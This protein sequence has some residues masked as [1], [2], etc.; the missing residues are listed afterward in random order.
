MAAVGGRARWSHGWQHHDVS[1]TVPSP[2]GL[3]RARLRWHEALAAL[4]ASAERA[5]ADAV[6]DD[7]LDRHAEVHRRYHGVAHV[8]SVES[9]VQRLLTECPADEVPA[10]PAVRGAVVA[11]AWFHDAVYDPRAVTNEEE[12][13]ALAARA[14]GSLGV[15]AAGTD[16]VA[17][18]VLATRDHV[19]VDAATAVLLDADL[20]VLGA[21][22]ATYEHYRQ[23]VRAEYAHVADPGWQVGRAQVLDR[24]LALPA[25][26]T[27]TV[28]REAQ[29]QARANL[30]AERAALSPGP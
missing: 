26:F 14:L 23:G 9:E 30:R 10:D 11:A 6:L 29:A 19:V 1:A 22:P 5:A 16:R 27:T 21:D 8:L 12:S 2:I 20:A 7:L 15:P 18:L 25:L 13:A 24:L 17:A 4:G 3:V 28:G